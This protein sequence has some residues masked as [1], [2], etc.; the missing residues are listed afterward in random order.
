MNNVD[1]VYTMWS[2]LRKTDGMDVG[3]VGFHKEKEVSLENACSILVCIDGKIVKVV[4]VASR[5][6]IFRN[7]ICL[8]FFFISSIN[9]T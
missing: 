8:I 4:H 1:V 2:N 9:V 3:Q 6:Y 7:D 5:F